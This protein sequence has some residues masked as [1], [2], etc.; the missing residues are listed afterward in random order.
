MRVK[1]VASFDEADHGLDLVT[2]DHSR[3]TTID[4]DRALDTREGHDGLINQE[5]DCTVPDIDVDVVGVYLD[6]HL[7]AGLPRF[8]SRE[9]ARELAASSRHLILR[10]ELLKSPCPSIGI[11]MLS[12]VPSYQVPEHICEAVM[13]GNCRYTR[14]SM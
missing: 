3:K 9:S 11:G 6:H 14:T 13:L 5:M 1:T 8:L 12:F 2:R 7:V 10:W 4:Q